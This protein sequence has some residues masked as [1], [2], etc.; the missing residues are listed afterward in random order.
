MSGVKHPGSIEMVDE[1]SGKKHAVDANSAPREVAFVGG[2][3]VVRIV[4]SRRGDQV[5]LRSYGVDGALLSTT[6]GTT[7]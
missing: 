1:E 2:Q 7:G 6:V 4:K 3:A 5:V